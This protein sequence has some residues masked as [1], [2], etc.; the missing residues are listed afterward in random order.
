LIDDALEFVIVR[1]AV[2]LSPEIAPEQFVIAPL[3]DTDTN[4]SPLLSASVLL[5]TDHVL[6]AETRF[7]AVRFVNPPPL[8]V[9]EFAVLVMFTT[10]VLPKLFVAAKAA[11]VPAPD[12]SKKFVF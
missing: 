7:V 10:T 2:C 11:A 4:Q 6:M 3:P 8:P 9:N 12:R 5:A 1:K